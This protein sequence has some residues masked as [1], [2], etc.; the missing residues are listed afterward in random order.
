[1]DQGA[2]YSAVNP[3]KTYRLELSDGSTVTIDGAD[4]ISTA[5]DMASLMRALRTKNP[6]IVK[7]ALARLN[8]SPV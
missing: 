7:A 5:E 6:G 4:L 2:I 1:M 3:L 8:R